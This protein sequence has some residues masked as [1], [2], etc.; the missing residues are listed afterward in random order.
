MEPQPTEVRIRMYNIGFGDC[1]LLTFVYPE[2]AEPGGPIHRHV[3][4]D[5]G[6]MGLPRVG[7][8]PLHNTST[9]ADDIVTTCDRPGHELTAVVATHRHQDHIS[10]FAGRSGTAIEKL[11]PKLVLQPW[12]EHPQVAEDAEQPIQ[13][14]LIGTRFGAL[15][16][17]LEHALADRGLLFVAGTERGHEFVD[18]DFDYE[19]Q[20]TI[21]RHHTESIRGAKEAGIREIVFV[22]NLNIK[23]RCAVERLARMGGE[24]GAEYLAAGDT[25]KLQAELP[26]V[27]IHVLG[28]PTAAEADLAHPVRTHET[29][30]WHLIG[31]AWGVGLPGP[32][33]GHGPEPRFPGRLATPIECRWVASHISE[34][35][36]SDLLGI[37][38]DLDGALNNTSLV[39]LFE[40]WT[41][42]ERRLLLF[43]GDAQLESWRHFLAD[44][45]KMALLAETDVYKV[46]HHGSLNATP[47]ERL[48]RRFT[49]REKGLLTMLS[50]CDGRHGHEE[51]CTE[52]PR[53][54]LVEALE[55]ES[56]FEDSRVLTTETDPLYRE[57]VVEPG[58]V[59]PKRSDTGDDGE[60]PTS[61]T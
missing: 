24:N 7:D 61:P 29:E 13:R 12:T 27:R 10:G 9:I 46:G 32:T 2:S 28:P 8:S 16:A 55:R 44:P 3:L 14:R 34:L 50:T 21:V 20:R 59:R 4:I 35:R 26:G 22:G 49:K 36:P 15:S 60:E 1:F 56:E 18:D 40:I 57:R 30:F 54:K 45:E 11:K 47:R 39:L 5:F 52:V 51:T 37:V 23:N 19:R 6:T 53:A 38:R 17:D 31:D 33:G 48:W 42:A 25:T 41:G 43:P 58:G